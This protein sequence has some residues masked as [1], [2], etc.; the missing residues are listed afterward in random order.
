M[1]HYP[2]IVRRDGTLFFACADGDRAAIATSIERLIDM[3]DAMDGDTDLEPSLAESFNEQGGS[4]DDRE[5]DE[6][7]FE[8]SLGAAE[9]HPNALSWID[10]AHTHSQEQWASGERTDLEDDGDDLEPDTDT[11]ANGD[12]LDVNGDEQDYSG[13]TDESPSADFGFDGT[14]EA[15]AK[16]MIRG[17]PQ[18]A[19]RARA[20]A[21]LGAFPVVYDFRGMGR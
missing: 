16:D 10:Q 11:E 4:G 9:R 2:D 6:A 13:F 12:E 3:L 7:D 14:G 19:A 17:M 21:A 8:P 5:G 15:E 1:E 18:A 20:Y